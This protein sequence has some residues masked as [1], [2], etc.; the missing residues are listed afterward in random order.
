[1]SRKAESAE[2][3]CRIL[4]VIPRFKPF[5]CLGEGARGRAVKLVILA[6]AVFYGV[7]L[8]IY[9]NGAVC[10]HEFNLCDAHAP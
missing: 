4:Y 9:C 3:Y 6:L 8:G 10:A 5:P 7:G 2:V 1:M